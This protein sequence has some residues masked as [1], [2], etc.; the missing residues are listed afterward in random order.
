MP[1]YERAGRLI[2][3]VHVPK[4][5]G[6][7]IRQALESEGWNRR[8]SESKRN[9]HA[10][11]KEWS[12]W[13]GHLDVDFEFAVIRHP[14]TRMQSLVNHWL[15]WTYSN[16]SA[17]FWGDVSTLESE[18]GLAFLRETG[19][20]EFPEGNDEWV[21]WVKNNVTLPMETLMGPFGLT[22]QQA[23]EITQIAHSNSWIL[24]RGW[25]KYYMRK[26][27]G[28]E[29]D[30]VKWKD[31]IFKF[32]ETWLDADGKINMDRDFSGQYIGPRPLPFSDF[33]GPN[34]QVYKLED[35][36]EAVQEELRKREILK[37][38]IPFLNRAGI[39][40]TSEQ[41]T[42]QDMYDI[43]VLLKGFYSKDYE[44]YY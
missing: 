16:R 13:Y 10:V 30:Q 41:D 22:E 1:I 26:T 8:D 44:F 4:A 2:H 14:D 6:T 9:P 7:S 5:G 23:T 31:L 42:K 33:L 18:E 12:E 37:G 20:T 36:L 19:M 17:S 40:F 43:V 32:F 34:T 28:K 29:P 15:R 27:F 39:K 24:A 38:E 11:F 21:E 3:F 25:F 35:G